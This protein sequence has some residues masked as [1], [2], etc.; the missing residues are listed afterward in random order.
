MSAESQSDINTQAARARIE[1][2]IEKQEGSAEAVTEK[3]RHINME[4]TIKEGLIIAKLDALNE[5]MLSNQEDTY[6]FASDLPDKYDTIIHSPWYAL[7]AINNYSILADLISYLMTFDWETL[8]LLFSVAITAVINP[9]TIFMQSTFIGD[10]VRAS[11][12]LRGVLLKAFMYKGELNYGLLS[13]FGIIFMET[14]V[15]QDINEVGAFKATFESKSP[16]GIKPT[17]FREEGVARAIL[18]VMTKKLDRKKVSALAQIALGYYIIRKPQDDNTKIKPYYL[19]TTEMASCN[20]RVDKRIGSQ[21]FREDAAILARNRTVDYD[22]HYQ[23][24]N[25]SRAILGKSIIKRAINTTEALSIRTK[26]L[27]T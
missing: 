14:N 5:E 16:L 22:D 8:L 11:S 19:F 7:N 9:R 4:G 27:P 21:V 13:A 12:K 24:D 15:F 25:I 20:V 2:I 18:E 26:T 3:L 1:E 23:V 10:M 17:K 6:D